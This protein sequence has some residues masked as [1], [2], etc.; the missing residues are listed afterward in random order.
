MQLLRQ[1][2]V[3]HKNIKGCVILHI[4]L[5]YVNFDK[6]YALQLMKATVLAESSSILSIFIMICLLQRYLWT[7]ARTVTH[8]N[9]KGSHVILHSL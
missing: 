2:T 1:S 9:L 6:K 5:L 8:K 7:V 3:T 4:E